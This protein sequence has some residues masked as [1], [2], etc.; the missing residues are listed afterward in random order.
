MILKNWIYELMKLSSFFLV[1]T[2]SANGIHGE[3]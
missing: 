1:S 2:A 3:T